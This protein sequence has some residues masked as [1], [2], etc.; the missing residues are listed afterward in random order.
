MC[1]ITVADRK[2]EILPGRHTWL[3]AV[4]RNNMARRKIVPNPVWNRI[5]LDKDEAGGFKPLSKE[6][7]AAWP[8]Y[9]GTAG[10]IGAEGKPLGKRVET[11]CNYSGGRKAAIY[12]ASA[13]QD[14]LV[15]TA[16]LC[17]HSFAPDGTPT[18]S[19]SDARTGTPILTEEG[20]LAA[21]EVIVRFNGNVYLHQFKIR[22][23]GDFENVGDEWTRSCISDCTVLGLVARDFSN[24]RDVDGRRDV[25]LINRPFLQFGVA[26]E[27]GGGKAPGEARMATRRVYP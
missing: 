1:V 2:I 18:I 27:A 25:G 10:V 22:K 16:V 14:G 20:M 21:A 24:W 6:I 23:G 3:E 7:V 11:T 19:L 9:T 8:L 13:G 4:H 5:F 26:V 12:E 15:D 17:D